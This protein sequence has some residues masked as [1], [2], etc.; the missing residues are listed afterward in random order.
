[1]IRLEPTDDELD[2]TVIAHDPYKTL[3]GSESPEDLT[4]IP[5]F[6]FHVWSLRGLTVIHDLTPC[7]CGAMRFRVIDGEFKGPEFTATASTAVQ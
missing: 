1:M 3:D 5:R 6:K 4:C 7:I 2:N